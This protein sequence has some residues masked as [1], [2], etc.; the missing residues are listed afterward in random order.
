MGQFDHL[1]QQGKKSPSG[2]VPVEAHPAPKIEPPP[3]PVPPV[4]DGPWTTG[5]LNIVNGKGNYYAFSAPKYERR[6][7]FFMVP[8]F[9]SKMH[10]PEM[11]RFDLLVRIAY[12]PAGDNFALIYSDMVYLLRGKGLRKAV[13]FIADRY[14]SLLQEF[15]PT[16]HRPQEAD[17]PIITSMEM[18]Q[19][20]D[21]N[22]PEWLQPGNA[23]K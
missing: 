20:R 2:P 23:S 1:F 10:C 16:L 4:E 9:Q 5:P 22:L 13:E 14:L 3:A 15:D 18:F 6:E 11:L 7:W 19:R 12:S 17:E 21:P 8:R